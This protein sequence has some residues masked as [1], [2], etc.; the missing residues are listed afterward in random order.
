MAAQPKPPFERQCIPGLI[1]ARRGALDLTLDL[2][3]P[4]IP[5]GSAHSRPLPLVVYYHG[6]GW[7][8]GSS[9][10][11]SS[12]YFGLEVSSLGVA[13][14]CVNYR[15]A[16]QHPAPAAVQDARL[17]VRWLRSEAPAFGLD[18][19]RVVSMGNSAGGHLALMTALLRSED[20]LDSPELAAHDSSVMAAI[21]L[22]GIADVEAL[23]SLSEPPIWVRAWIPGSGA[24]SAALARRCSPIRHARADAPPVLIIHAKDDPEVPFEQSER[25]HA[26]LAAAGADARLSVIESG[27]HM[28]GVTGSPDVQRHVRPAIRSFLGSLGLLESA[29]EGNDD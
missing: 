9:G 28:L 11:P 2:Y 26:A 21:D 4:E 22:C 5:G 20:G 25:I 1:Y 8:R 17:A 3:L 19:D 7:C 27:G 15:L 14:A 10:S 12:V 16:P 6:G 13:V 24:D 18:S 29:S 23:F